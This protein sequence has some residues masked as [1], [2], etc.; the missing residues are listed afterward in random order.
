M[1]GGAKVWESAS[2]Q[3]VTVTP[4]KGHHVAMTASAIRDNGDTS[5]CV[6]TRINNSNG[7][8]YSFHG[9]LAHQSETGDN[10]YGVCS[11]AAEDVTGVVANTVWDLDVQRVKNLGTLAFGSGTGAQIV[12]T[13]LIVWNLGEEV[14]AAV[15]TDVELEAQTKTLVDY[16][17]SGRAWGA[18][19]RENSNLRSF[20]RGLAH[21][22]D[23]VTRDIRLFQDEILPDR[24]TL[25]L[26]EWEDC[27]AIPDNCFLGTGSNDERRTDLLTK[28]ASV[29]VQTVS[30][31]TALAA[32][33]DLDITIGTGVEHGTLPL[34]L[35][36]VLFAS[37]TAPRFSIVV[38][39]VVPDAVTFPYT[40]PIPF[41]TPAL[42]ILECLF[43]ELK[44]A[45]CQVVFIGV[46]GS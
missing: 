12:D 35:P 45:N 11:I 17:P 5:N 28:L 39:Y 15:S 25:F 22:L 34:T 44:P 31:F 8:F 36:F 32:K 18:K 19:N 41:T 30:D 4:T 7:N 13:N 23:R 33:F 9:G 3:A 16:L 29:G 40:F 43:N 6:R 42:T 21:E 10:S 24:T 37:V 38:S 20:F 14:E 27:V 1:T 2:N 26:K 46:S